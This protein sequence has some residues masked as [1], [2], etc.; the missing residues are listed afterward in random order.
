MKDSADTTVTVDGDTIT[1]LLLI[2]KAIERKAMPERIKML[3]KVT[4]TLV[5]QAQS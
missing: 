3:G 4:R 2:V 5:R 1:A